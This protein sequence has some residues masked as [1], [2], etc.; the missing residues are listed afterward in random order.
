MDDD[1]NT[2]VALAVLFD[3]ARELNIAKQAANAQLVDTL[4]SSLRYLGDVLGILQAEAD[5]FLQGDKTDDDAAIEQ[6]IQDRITAK[7]NKN[8]ASADQIRDQLK[9]QGIILEDAP[10]GTTT[11]R[12]D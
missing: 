6:L 3:L 12:R 8:W 5:S 2:P 11:W 1:F 4:A 9:Q 10:N 7:H